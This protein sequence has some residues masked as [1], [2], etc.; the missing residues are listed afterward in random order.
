[1]AKYSNFETLKITGAHGASVDLTDVSMFTHVVNAN[2]TNGTTTI[3]GVQAG[4]TFGLTTSNDTN[5]SVTIDLQNENNAGDETTITF[6]TTA[7]GVTLGTVTA[8]DFETLNYNT[9]GASSVNSLVDADL[10]TLNVSGAKPY[11]TGAT[12]AN[13]ATIDASAMTGNFIMGAAMGKQLLQSP[14][15]QV[16][17]LYMP[18]PVHQLLILALVMTHQR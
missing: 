16:P 3:A 9:G 4:T 1:M 5:D 18:V 10:A 7:A 17:I 11:N 2:A 15:V 6:G 8:S 13:L 14:Q 12:A